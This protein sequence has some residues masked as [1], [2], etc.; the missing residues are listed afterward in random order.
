MEMGDVE[1]VGLKEA[2][3]P[4]DPGDPVEPEPEGEE[5]ISEEP[6]PTEVVATPEEPEVLG[7]CPHAR[8]LSREDAGRWC[9]WRRRRRGS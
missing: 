3:G 2:A 9:R 5:G 8:A 7:G 4:E 1:W 6:P